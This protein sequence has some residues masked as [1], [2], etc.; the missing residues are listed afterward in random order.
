RALGQALAT[1]GGSVRA[2]PLYTRLTGL[3]V[4]PGDLAVVEGECTTKAEAA[5]RV[6]AATE[7]RDRADRIAREK[8]KAEKAR[9]AAEE[10]A[11]RAGSEDRAA[12]EAE[13]A[14]FGDI[15]AD[16]EKYIRTFDY[17]MALSQGDKVAGRLRAAD[18]KAQLED[19]LSI[20]RQY[21]A[22]LTRLRKDINA[23]AL[24]DPVVTFGRDNEGKGKLTEATAKDYAIAIQGGQARMK[25]KDLR[26]AQLLDLLRRM[27]LGP[28]DQFVLGSWCLEA[29]LPADANRAFVAALRDSSKKRLIDEALARYYG[30]N[31]PEGGFVLFLGRLVT[32]T[33]KQNV[34]AGL[35]FYAG[36]W[37]TPEDR[38]MLEKG[39]RKF[40]NKWA[41]EEAELVAAGYIKY[42]E[43]W[44]TPEELDVLR[45][46]WDEA[47]EYETAHYKIR[48]NLADSFGKQLCQIL[49]QAYA[50]YAKHFGKEPPAAKMT[51]LA[52]RTFEDY[53]RY[54]IETKAEA[55][56]QALGFANPATNVCCGYKKFGT[57][58]MIG[59]MIHEGAHLFHDRAHNGMSPSW[60]HEGHAT[61]FEG[62]VWDGT[63]LT[64]NW[65]PGNRIYWLKEAYRKDRLIPMGDI[66]R[67]DAL[68]SI[69]KGV[70]ESSLFYSE[71]WALYT[72]FTEC[73]DPEIAP[74]WSALRTR[75]DTGRGGNFSGDGALEMVTDVFG[76]D[77]SAV[78]AKWK[79]WIGG[80]K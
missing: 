54:C 41:K 39:F 56:L 31:V 62:F 16:L 21:A 7:A 30:I 3:R 17:D 20:V 43:L 50:A 34:E 8:E 48:C 15:L 75:F 44:Y 58:D 79:E 73:T 71:S 40:G 4:G 32:P 78:E 24:R 64:F 33:E 9:K 55:Y 12:L 29:D 69:N 49:E 11:A 72:F 38:K 5:A 10:A 51:M 45:S 57:D 22:L 70:D 68:S 77:L 74:K 60:Y 23:G 80:L 14:T 42:K 47:W 26:P 59:T 35:V 2:A 36:Q 67:G 46:N 37:V 63:T 25:W 13:R 66:M 76:P 28:S 65:R 27:D 19:R 61:Y 53:R 18:L 6:A 52:F 1:P